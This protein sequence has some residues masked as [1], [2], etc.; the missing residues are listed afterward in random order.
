MYVASSPSL[1]AGSYAQST[2]PRFRIAMFEVST[3]VA[4]ANFPPGV[5]G[6]KIIIFST[7]VL[8]IFKSCTGNLQCIPKSLP[9]LEG[10][11]TETAIWIDRLHRGWTRKIQVSQSH[12]QNQRVQVQQGAS[13]KRWFY[14]FCRVAAPQLV[15]FWILLSTRKGLPRVVQ[16]TIYFFVLFP[17]FGA[18]S[19]T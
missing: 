17:T 14:E 5:W 16:T 11:S 12:F 13:P 7:C 10:L 15:L 9:D 4:T 19:R 6:V 8:A 3:F 2:S 18:A 1:I